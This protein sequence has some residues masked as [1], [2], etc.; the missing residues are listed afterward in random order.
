MFFKVWAER[1]AISPKLRRKS[2]VYRFFMGFTLGESKKG[3]VERGWRRKWKVESIKVKGE[4]KKKKEEN[5]KC[6]V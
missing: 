1:F 6:R 2:V 3:K 4:S 5:I